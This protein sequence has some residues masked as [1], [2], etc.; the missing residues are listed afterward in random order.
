MEIIIALIVVVVFG[1]MFYFNRSSNSLDVNSDGKV[2]LAD[3]KTA[4]VNTVSGVKKA[5][6]ADGDGKV[7]VK[8]AKAAAKKVKESAAKTVAK[9]KT[10]VATKTAAKAKP[11][12]AKVATAKPK[13]TRK[14]KEV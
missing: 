8:D 9:A 5:A 11:K 6:D 3:A 1:A 14:K 7:T 10:K 13:T 4:L 12:T 2:D